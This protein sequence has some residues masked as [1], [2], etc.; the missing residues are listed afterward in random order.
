[1]FLRQEELADKGINLKAW[2]GA[3]QRA[4]KGPD[5]PTFALG[6]PITLDVRTRRTGG[7]VATAKGRWAFMGGEEFKIGGISSDRSASTESISI[8]VTLVPAKMSLAAEISG[9]SLTL[10]EC[11]DQLDGFEQ[12]LE[13]FDNVKYEEPQMRPAP[14]KDQREANPMWGSW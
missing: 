9:M 6:G 13:S 14:V 7:T 4:A 3:V 11:L 10:Q 8:T 2:L 12:W 1:M 5:A